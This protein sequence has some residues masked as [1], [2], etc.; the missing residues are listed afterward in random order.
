MRRASGTDAAHALRRIPAAFH[1]P[2]D[3]RGRTDPRHQ[4]T[5][6]ADVE[7][8]LQPP[9]V[10]GRNSHDAPTAARRLRHA[11][12]G[13]RI[14]GPVLCIDEQPA[15]AGP[16]MISAISAPGSP[17]MVPTRRLPARKPVMN[18][19]ATA[20]STIVAISERQDSL[21]ALF[22]SPR[23][24]SDSRPRR[25]AFRRPT[26]ASSRNPSRHRAV[27]RPRASGTG[28]GALDG[29]RLGLDGRAERRR[30]SGARLRAHAGDGA[31]L[32]GLR[33]PPSI[34]VRPV[35]TSGECYPGIRNSLGNTPPG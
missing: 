10:S 1:H 12:R 24:A 28:T 8:L 3:L 19:H 33:E 26:A 11:L 32:T 6:G 20:Q 22:A 16:A 7:H 34:A 30:V 27:L 14:D 18:S 13:E 21:R 25:T 4:H 9:F 17:T 23:G 31:W 5:G 15:E 2:F 35:W 29:G